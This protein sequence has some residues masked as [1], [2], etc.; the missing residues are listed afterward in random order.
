MRNRLAIL[1]LFMLAAAAFFSWQ[2]NSIVTSSY[3]FRDAKIP[4]GFRGFRIVQVSDL[5]NK[6]FGRNHSA[7]LAKIRAARPDILV[8]TGDLID[9][10]RTDLAAAL[11]FAEAAIQIAPVYYVSGNHEHSSGVY[12]ELTSG[13]I[14]AGVIVLDN[15]GIVLERGTD[16]I[17][18]LGLA[19]PGFMESGHGFVNSY[20]DTLA[21]VAAGCEQGFTMLLS[22][23][24]EFMDIY[25]RQEIDLVLSGHAHGG[26]FRLPGLGGL[27]A[28]GQ[29]L[30]PKYTS[31][32]Y[33]Q[34]PTAMLVSRGLGNSIFPLRIF[35]RPELVVVTLIPE[36]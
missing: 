14:K 3:N 1:V 24:P 35:N 33:K 9:R 18:L 23:H 2:N 5:H 22:H 15:A 25:A 31:G 13:L 26:Q 17:A 32:L 28:P 10:S 30:F 7:L 34:G 27:I 20:A 11:G 21:A 36:E 29:G 12:P 4:G 6:V 16:Q 8:I 19:D